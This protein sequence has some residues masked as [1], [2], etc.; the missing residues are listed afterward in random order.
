MRMSGKANRNRW[1]SRLPAA[2]RVLAMVWVVMLGATAY[3]QGTGEAGETTAAQVAQVAQPPA[4]QWLDSPRSTMTTFLLGMHDIR[5]GKSGA[6]E[7]VLAC[8]DFG[9]TARGDQRSHAEQLYAILNRIETID[10]DLLPDV[11]ETQR[12]GTDH[13]LYFPSMTSPRHQKVLSA[14]SAPLPGRIAFVKQPDGRWVF[15]AATVES[16]PELYDAMASLPEVYD[17][18]GEVFAA[19]GPTFQ[20]TALWQWLALFGAIFAG[21]TIGKVIQSGVKAAA[22][23]LHAT[24]RAARGT[25]LEDAAGPLGLVLLTLGIQV[26]MHFIHMTDPLVELTE[27]VTMFLYILSVGWLLYNLVDVIDLW[28]REVAAKT[29]SKLD[30]MIVPLVRKALRIFLVIIFTLVVAQNVFGL[31]ITGWLA[32]LGIAGLAI[33]LAAQD[34]VKNLFGSVTVFFDKPF[35]VGDFIAFD[36]QEG[37]VEEIGFRSTRM[38]TLDGHLVTVPNMKFIDNNVRNITARRFLRR[39][40]NVT[41]TYD[42]PPEKIEQAVQII[43]DLL[44][45]PDMTAEFDLEKFPPR[46]VFDDFNADSLNIMVMY[47]YMLR[48]GKTIWDARALAQTFNL[49]LFRAF[50]E[51]GIE[52]AFPTQTLYLAGDPKR[53]LSVNVNDAGK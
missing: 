37:T 49:R 6:W 45:M 25:A 40:M 17:S 15:S 16:V 19:L 9:D 13:L 8:F 2:C 30:D 3:A 24:H 38:R 52:F 50:A 47:W 46:V 41:I 14:M 35:A 44:A 7:R 4:P 22:D 23:R 28:I 29:E 53:T 33:S 10:V 21:L 26:G 27:R 1:A 20:R 32:G 31:N 42:T 39:S 34:S 36:G 18:R 51:A 43:R 48:D 5:D 11:S 12:A